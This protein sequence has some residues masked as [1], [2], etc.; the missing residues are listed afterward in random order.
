MQN[1]IFHGSPINYV[2][3]TTFRVN[4]RRFFVDYFTFY[5]MNFQTRTL[6]FSRSVGLSSTLHFTEIV[7]GFEPYFR[8]RGLNQS[9]LHTIHVTRSDERS[10]EKKIHNQSTKS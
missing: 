10:G 4:K 5:L 6:F 8:I 2:G 3:S 1:C 7:V 9:N